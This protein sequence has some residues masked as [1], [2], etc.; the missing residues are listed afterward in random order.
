RSAELG[1]LRLDEAARPFDLA[2]GP[3]V[4]AAL[5]RLA[6]E[7]HALLLSFHHAVYDGWSEGVLLRELAALYGAAR[8]G[9]PSPLPSPALQY[10]DYAAWQRAWPPAVLAG[11]LAYWRG[12]LDGAPQAL[13]LPAD[14]PRPAVAS[15]RGA[16]CRLLLPAAEL[17][18]LRQAARR[19]G[20][21]LYMLLLA[22]F[23]AALQRHGG[24]EDL[25]L[26]TPVANR[27]RPELEGLLGFFVNTLALRLK[28][29]GDPPFRRLLAAAR[30]TALAAFAHQD[31]PFEALVEE[32]RPERDLSRAPLVQAMI[33]LGAAARPERPLAGGLS[34][35][36]LPSPERTTAKLDLSLAATEIGG[37]MGEDA[38]RGLLLELEYA[39][40]LFHPTTAAR[41][42]AHVAALLVGAAAE[43]ELPLS[44]LPLLAAAERHQLVAEWNDTASDLPRRTVHGL[45]AAQAAARPGAVALSWEGGAMSYG[46]LARRALAIARSLRGLGVEPGARVGLLAERSPEMIAALLGI[47]AAGGGYLPLDP[48]YPRARLDLLL[49]DAA[50][51]AVVGPGRFLG[52]LPESMPRLA[53]DALDEGPWLSLVPRTDAAALSWDEGSPDGLAYVLY[54]SGSTGRPKGVEIVHRGIVR[55]VREPGYAEFGPGETFLQLSPMSFDAATIEIWAA[56]ANGGRLAILRP[57]P[58]ALADV[59]DAVAREGVTTLF[60]TTGLFHLAV[61]EGLA[62]LAGLHQLLSGGDVMSREHL[63]RAMAALP[64]VEIVHCYGPTE[65]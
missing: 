61:E 39:A 45:F 20:A 16:G 59:Y 56:L 44:R 55:L 22:A 9:R 49:S 26:G 36:R 18:R 43:P 63:E 5:A 57:G 48:S 2:R 25:V 30:E 47:L 37:E 41:L 51:A 27:T 15:L 32:L 54:T 38:E 7:E 4:R 6:A 50:P 11:Q 35:A 17:D 10:A 52:M 23:A 53:L 24:Q 1:R 14:R 34:I 46:E 31:L 42:L 21:T 33:S 19:E 64:G 13:E 8:D 62:P 40:D 60:L 65:N 58:F 28:P 29:A 3:L 12:Q